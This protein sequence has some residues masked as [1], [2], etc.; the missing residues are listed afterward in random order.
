MVWSHWVGEGICGW[1]W[2]SPN[3]LSALGYLEAREKKRLGSGRGG[4]E[5][6]G[7]KVRAEGKLS[8]AA[9]VST[10]VSPLQRF[11]L[12]PL[13]Y[14]VWAQWSPQFCDL[15]MCFWSNGGVKNQPALGSI[16]WKKCFSCIWLRFW[17]IHGADGLPA[18]CPSGIAIWEHYLIWGAESLWPPSTFHSQWLTYLHLPSKSYQFNFPS[19]KG[20]KENG[21]PGKKWEA[22]LEEGFGEEVTGINNS[23]RAVEKHCSSLG[24]SANTWTVRSRERRTPLVFSLGMF[25]FEIFECAGN[26][27]WLG[28]EQTSHFHLQLESQALSGA[29]QAQTLGENSLEGDLGQ[30]PTS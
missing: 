2:V 8:L 9:A 26:P 20:R 1:V 22:I 25:L 19:K 4:W 15:D 29:K 16:K 13:V 14:K 6:M 5:M 10:S 30:D 23:T 11:L 18:C 27:S 12:S 24:S 21:H 17:F 3:P 7:R 28:G